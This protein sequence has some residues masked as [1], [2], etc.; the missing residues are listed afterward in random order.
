MRV[1]C[2]E[3]LQNV[4]SKASRRV[5]GCGGLIGEGVGVRASGLWALRFSF[6]VW[7]LGLGLG[8][9][10]REQGRVH[11]VR[12]FRVQRFKVKSFVRVSRVWVWGLISLVPKHKTP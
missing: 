3:R 4:S 6:G 5:E 1:E 2:A 7:G 8:L 11:M 12:A 10:F 9:K